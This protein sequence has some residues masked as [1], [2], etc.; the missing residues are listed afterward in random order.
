MTKKQ[1]GA[2]FYG[3]VSE[4]FR[5]AALGAEFKKAGAGI[6]LVPV[7]CK[8]AAARMGRTTM[9]ADRGTTTGRKSC[10]GTKSRNFG[11]SIQSTRT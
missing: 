7:L 9:P 5:K 2:L 11:G 10:V 6:L 1:V 4:Q 8:E 3:D